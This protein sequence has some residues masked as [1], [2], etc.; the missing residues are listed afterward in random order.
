MSYS[1]THTNQKH[2]FCNRIYTPCLLGSTFLYH[3]GRLGKYHF[4][5]FDLNLVVD[6]TIRLFYYFQKTS[7]DAIR[8]FDLGPV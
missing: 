8:N 6:G 4:Y 3:V 5:N 7:Y 1:G 2:N